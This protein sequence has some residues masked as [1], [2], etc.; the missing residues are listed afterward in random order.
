MDGFTIVDL[1]V[2]GIIL[3][4]AVLAYARGLVR[5]TLA[6]AGWIGAAVLA[7]TFA[8][9]FEPLVK[10][11]PVVGDV[12]GESCQFAVIA[13]FAAVF[14]LSLLVISIFT[15]LL[16]GWVRGSPLGAIDQALGFLFGAVR[17]VLL[18]AVSFVVYD[19]GRRRRRLGRGGREPVGR[20]LLAL[21]R[22]D[23]R[24]DPRRRARLD[25]GALRDA[26]RPLRRLS[27]AAASRVVMAP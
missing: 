22:D 21:A 9:A 7:F 25:R 2:A 17:G 24:A 19:A 3:V 20:D 15:P 12:V 11:I 16:S 6:I 26:R 13:S 14:V 8:G 23:R 27:H 10:E 1:A 18:V 4:S 5:E